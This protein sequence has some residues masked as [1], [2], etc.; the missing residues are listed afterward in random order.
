M[1]LIEEALAMQPSTR[2]S[3][4][5]T[6][7]FLAVLLGWIAPAYAYLDPATGSILL[8]GLIAGVAGLVVVLRLY[9]QRLKALFRRMLGQA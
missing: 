7:I 9:W 8:Q 2:P 4:I 1:R 6:A 5:Q 3:V